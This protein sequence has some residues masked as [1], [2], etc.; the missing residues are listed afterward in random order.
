MVKCGHVGDEHLVHVQA[1]PLC[2]ITIVSASSFITA[3]YI[4]DHLD[5]GGLIAC[6]I[7]EQV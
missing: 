4:S 1:I 7:L 5:A 2:R 3:Y 6:Y